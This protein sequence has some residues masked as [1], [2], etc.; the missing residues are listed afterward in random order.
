MTAQAMVQSAF[1]APHVTE[2]IT[3]DVTKTM[4]LVENLKR[5]QEFREVKVTPLLVLAKALCLAIAG[6]R[7]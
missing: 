3:I 5:D 2:W 1:T 4:E 6:T 7:A